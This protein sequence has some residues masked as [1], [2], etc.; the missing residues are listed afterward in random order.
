MFPDA[1]DQGV[2]ATREDVSSIFENLCRDSIGSSAFIVFQ[3]CNG[4]L[5]F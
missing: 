1:L 2:Q 4:L 5:D 3:P